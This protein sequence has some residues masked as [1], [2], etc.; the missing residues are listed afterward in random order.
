MKKYLYLIKLQIGLA[1]VYRFDFYWRWVFAIV[2]VLVPLSIWTLTTKGDEAKTIHMVLYFV[3][4]QGLLGNIHTARTSYFIARSISRGDAKNILLK[5]IYFPVVE[6]IRV[7]SVILARLC[8]PFVIFIFLTIL[9]PHIFAPAG[10]SEFLAF[11]VF[12]ILGTLVWNLIMIIVGI[13]AFWFIEIH[14]LIT[15]VDLTFTFL[16]GAVVPFFLFPAI[17]KSVLNV[18]PI[19]YMLAF[20]IEIYSGN[21]PNSQLLLP[22]VVLLIWTIFLVIIV[23][24]LYPKGLQKYDSYG[25]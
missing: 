22:F 9:F 1:T 2:Q 21:I 17:V 3:L 23:K 15:V 16:K 14:N 25:A 18:T 8:I 5:P 20:P 11:M 10:I 12:V 24:V 13:L 19:P 7:I 6:A 4:F